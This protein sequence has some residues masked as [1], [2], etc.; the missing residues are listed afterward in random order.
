MISTTAIKEEGGE[1]AMCNS[2]LRI[3]TYELPP[4][5]GTQ[6]FAKMAA[7]HGLHVVEQTPAGITVTGSEG[8][9]EIFANRLGIPNVNIAARVRSRSHCLGKLLINHQAASTNRRA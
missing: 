2:V 5:V 8:D 9:L 3:K 1:L 7:T 6:L 4:G